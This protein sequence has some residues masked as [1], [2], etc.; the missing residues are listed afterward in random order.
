MPSRLICRVI[1]V[2]GSAVLLAGAAGT[3]AGCSSKDRRDQN[4]GTD[5][6]TTYV[7]PEAG[8]PPVPRVRADAGDAGPLSDAPDAA[9]SSGDGTGDRVSP[10]APG[11][12]G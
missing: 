11:A 10:D 2:A 12:G 9:G 6:G 7:A 5:T 3:G 1:A 4:Y 8:P